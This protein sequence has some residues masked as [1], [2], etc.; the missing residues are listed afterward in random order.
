MKK[1]HFVLRTDGRKHAMHP[2]KMLESPESLRALSGELGW[3]VY[4][5]LREPA[6]PMDISRKLG[7]HE[8]RIY[9]Y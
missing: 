3:K 9:Y 4:R 6:C 8:Q 1:Q 7:V 2:V 5:E